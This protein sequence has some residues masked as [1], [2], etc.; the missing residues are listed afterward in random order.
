LLFK[1]SFC[2]ISKYISF[3][4]HR[5]A[6]LQYIVKGNY[7]V[8]A[9]VFLAIIG[10]DILNQNGKI[11]GLALQYM[12]PDLALDNRIGEQSVSGTILR[13]R[14]PQPETRLRQQQPQRA[15]AYSVL[16]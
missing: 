12:P 6:R 5:V 10:V 11:Y 3:N 1:T 7:T 2:Y 16:P 13:S 4:K 8:E 15:Q 9:K 14:P